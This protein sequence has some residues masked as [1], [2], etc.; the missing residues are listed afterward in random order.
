MQT[1]FETEEFIDKIKR[2]DIL[3]QTSL[4]KAYTVQIYNA[5]L[6]MGFSGVDA[7]DITQNVWITFFDVVQNFQGRSKIRTYLF[8]IFY[9]KASEYRKK[10]NKMDFSVDVEALLEKQFDQRG[11]WISSPQDPEKFLSATQSMELIADCLERLPLN[12]KLILR[13]KEIEEAT[14][15]EICNILGVTATHIGVLLFRAKNQMRACIER[16]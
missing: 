4:V 3:A 2:R 10:Q 5:A 12:Q 14:T 13:L 16:K 8:G 1:E 9:N 6:G 11:H 7:D 15:E